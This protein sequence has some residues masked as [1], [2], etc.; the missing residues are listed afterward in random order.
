MAKDEGEGEGEIIYNY[1]RFDE[2]EE[3]FSSLANS[4]RLDILYQKIKKHYH[5]L[6]RN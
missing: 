3:I 5:R 1:S 6:Q 4:Q 2:T